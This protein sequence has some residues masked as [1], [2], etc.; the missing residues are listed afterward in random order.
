VQ[1]SGSSSGEKLS[2]NSRIRSARWGYSSDLPRRRRWGRARNDVESASQRRG[3]RGGEGKGR[4]SRSKSAPNSRRSAAQRNNRRN[5]GDER[6]RQQ[7]RHR[8]RGGA[9]GGDRG[10]RR[11]RARGCGLWGILS[12]RYSCGRPRPKKTATVHHRVLCVLVLYS[13]ERATPAAHRERPRPRARGARHVEGEC[14]LRRGGDG[15][16]LSGWIGYGEGNDDDEPACRSLIVAPDARRDAPASSRLYCTAAPR[17]H[18]APAPVP[19]LQAATPA[20]QRTVLVTGGKMAKSLFV[21]RALWGAGHRLV[22][23]ETEKYWCSGSRLSRAVWASATVPDPRYTALLIS[24][25]CDAY[26]SGTVATHS[27]LCRGK[28]TAAR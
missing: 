23:V 5:G 7:Q 9:A 17:L 3:G 26:K 14:A 24:P 28:H 10:P 4:D 20:R 21:A 18:P 13:K 11:T 8:R 16:C 25:A 15:A 2:E 27:C 1:R 19:P 6:R 22:L 12:L